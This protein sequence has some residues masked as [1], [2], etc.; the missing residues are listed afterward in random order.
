[1]IKMRCVVIDDEP[2]AI[3]ILTGYIEKLGFLELSGSFRNSRKALSFLAGGETDLLLLDINMPYLSG[4]ELLDSLESRPLVIFT[5][6]YS[7]Y[8]AES[9]EYDAV[10][11]LL[12]PVE[13]DRFVKAAKKAL[14]RFEH[15][16]VACGPDGDGG[17]RESILVKSGSSYHRLDVRDILFVRAAGNYVSFVTAEKEIMVL[18]RMKDVGAILP[19][20]NFIRVHRSFIVPVDRVESIGKE[21]LRIGG[22]SIPVGDK[23]RKALLERIGG[24]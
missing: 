6:A 22:S 7:E 12:K 18:M 15:S 16:R 20:D 1:M 11:Y 8:A 24:V 2:V 23:Y 4:I 3:E 14:S 13:F 19:D 5:T 21:K 9:Y 10:D 17:P